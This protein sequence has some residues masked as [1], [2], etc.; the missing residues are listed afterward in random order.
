MKTRIVGIWY[1]YL[2]LL[3]AAF[4]LTPFSATQVNAYTTPLVREALAGVAAPTPCASCWPCRTPPPIREA[5]ARAD[6][7]FIGKAIEGDEE[8]EEAIS[9]GGKIDLLS[10]R[11]RFNVVWVFNGVKRSEAIV[12]TLDDYCIGFGPF[13]KG[14]RYLL[15]ARGNEDQGFFVEP[16]T[17][18]ER[19]S[20]AGEDLKILSSLSPKNCG[21]RL[22][23]MVGYATGIKITAT[24]AQGHT[25]EAVSN[26]G[27]FEIEGV[28]A[29]VEYT[30]E[31]HL[32][33]YFQNNQITSTAVRINP[34][35]WKV[36][37]FPAVYDSSISGRV[38][39]PD[40][41]PVNN[42]VV[43]LMSSNKTGPWSDKSAMSDSQGRYELRDIAPGAYLLRV[44]ITEAPE[45]NRPYP[46]TW[47][48]NAATRQSAAI[49]EMGPGQKLSGYE[50]TI[51]R[52]LAER[53]IEGTVFWPDGRPAANADVY[54]SASMEPGSGAPKAVYT[55]DQGRF[56]V[57]GYEGVTY[58]VVASSAPN[59]HEPP[60]W[61][62]FYAEPPLVELGGEKVTGLKLT[63]TWDEETLKDFFKKK[64]ESSKK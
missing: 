10:G 11:V 5:L 15:Y 64:R 61:K 8:K 18:T 14:E 39:G 22:Y 31:A 3:V 7:V 58:Y 48:P 40:G 20:S 51:S 23:G 44:N 41:N 43:E 54:L 45:K 36:V 57:T 50:I 53:T 29:N 30:V 1:P 35:G 2:A 32:P 59:R 16:C 46:P 49:I 17:R 24:D 56:K 27:Y 47:Y 12:M 19:I 25:L 33:D 55:D 37:N 52:R 13:T 62:W 60:V 21:V 26:V 34:C 42:A 6:A 38:I 63:L 28:R 4:A 9:N